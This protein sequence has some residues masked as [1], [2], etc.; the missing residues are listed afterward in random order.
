MSFHPDP[1][2]LAAAVCTADGKHDGN[3]SS[4]VLKDSGVNFTTLNIKLNTDIVRNVTDGSQGVITAV[5]DTTI[6]ADGFSWNNGDDYEIR[7]GGDPLGDF[8]AGQCNVTVTAFDDEGDQK[9]DNWDVVANGAKALICDR[10]SGTVIGK[11]TLTFGF[12]AE[13]KP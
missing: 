11:A 13:K 9:N 3:N 12:V 10:Q 7:D 6:T 8:G 1:L 5:S 4:P 2:A